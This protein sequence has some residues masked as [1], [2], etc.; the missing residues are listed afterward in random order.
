M[1]NNKGLSDFRSDTVTQPDEAM[2]RAMAEAVVGDDVFGDDP[3]VNELQRQAAALFGKEAA[4]FVP[5]GTMG[6]LIAQKVHCAAGDEVILE[7]RS[8]MYNFE[9]GGGAWIAGVQVRL[10]KGPAGCMPLEDIEAAIRPANDPHCPTTRLVGI[11]NT[12]NFYGGRVVPLS[13]LRELSEFCRERGLKLHMDG[14]RVMNALV[15]TGLDP[16]DYGQCVDSLMVCLSKGLGAPVGSLLISSKAVIAQ[17]HRVR[18]AL[19]GGMR[20]VGVLAAPGLVAL[21][22]GPKQLAQD[23]KHA[24]ALAEG[25]GAIEGI[26]VDLAACE[27]N[28]LFITC[29]RDP[30]FYPRLTEFMAKEGV[31]AVPLAALG[32]RFVTHKHIDRSDVERALKVVA[33]GMAAL[34]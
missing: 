31:L 15:A 3:T 24:R 1:P 20:Q 33:E 32:I 14:A 5:S 10:V 7:S 12:H 19:G 26:K 27:T 18:K 29:D 28:I 30:S 16:K 21:N 25:L 22:E 2:R 17:A 6:N 34:T 13:Y 11:E 8:H 4:L 23:H 9:G